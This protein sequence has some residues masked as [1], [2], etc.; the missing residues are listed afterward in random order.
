MLFILEC[1]STQFPMQNAQHMNTNS[2][3]DGVKSMILTMAMVKGDSSNQSM[4]KT[5]ILM[6]VMSMLDSI[7]AQ[8]KVIWNMMMN[9]IEIQMRGVKHQPNIL[10]AFTKTKKSSVMVAIELSSKNPTSDAL[11]DCLTQLPHAKCILMRNG[12]V[13][14]NHHDEI[15]ISPQVFA[16]LSSTSS[17]K[18][19]AASDST[20]ETTSETNNSVSVSTAPTEQLQ[21]IEVYSYTFDMEQLRSFI[22]ELVNSYL[23]K[24]TNKLGNHIYYFSEQPA[25]VY[26]DASG[27]ID[28]SKSFDTLTF[29]MKRFITNRNFKN[30][31]GNEVNTIRKRVE[32]FKNNKQWYDEKGVPYTLGILVSGFPGTGKTSLIKCIANE[33]KRHIVNV[34]LSDNMTKTQLE[35]LFYNDQLHVTQNGK[36]DTY[37]IPIN[38][39]IYVLEDVDCQCDVVLDRVTETMEAKLAKQNK[40]LKQEIEK[41]K[42]ALS[43]ISNGKKVVMHSQIQSNLPKDDKKEDE[44]DK[45][46]LSFL[47]NLFD[48]VLET[49]GRIIF[50]TTNF[51]DKLDKAFTRPGRIDVVAELGF[52][53]VDQIIKIVEH[54]Y[55]CTLSAEQRDLICSLPECITPAEVGRI[56]FENF[57]NLDGALSSLVST[58]EEQHALQLKMEMERKE[59][60]R[61]EKE[62]E[63]KEKEREMQKL[64][65]SGRSSRSN[66]SSGSGHDDDDGCGHDDDDGCGHDDDDTTDIRKIPALISSKPQNYFEPLQHSFGMQTKPSQTTQQPAGSMKKW[67]GPMPFNDTLFM[68]HTVRK[69]P[70]YD[71]RAEPS[72]LDDGLP[73]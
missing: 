24:I 69:Q 37:T 48:G 30:L 6:I 66:R 50:M 14:L 11:I 1:M 68:T 19:M 67:T 28:R 55:D 62:R 2:I 61:A 54:R 41:L 45:V 23:V 26:K 9:R 47:L 16:K 42:H 44:N 22:T 57:D 59:K 60:E 32:F 71:I 43:E 40:E 38:K 20:V 34:H 33:L 70:S 35:H 12:Q 58:A 7:V 65:R 46:T 72:C 52:T 53:K 64:N 17:S 51:V 49:P 8:I 29:S 15:S 63:E 10:N 4:V 39:R 18:S 5:V 36:T 31:F 21:Y 56:L 27:K 25:M 73:N 13:Y 3:I